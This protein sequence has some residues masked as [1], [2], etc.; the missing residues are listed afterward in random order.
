MNY[1]DLKELND[2]VA[3]DVKRRN[4]AV[5]GVA[6]NTNSP[7]PSKYHNQRTAYNGRI[8]DSK[9]EML[10]AQNNDLRVKAGEIAFWLYHV[11]FDLPGGAVYESDAVTFRFCPLPYFS[12][13][14]PDTWYIEVQEVK[15]YWLPAAKRKMKLFKATYPNIKITVK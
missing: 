5:F 12:S 8:Y 2:N 9:K 11:R 3:D 14:E 10:N 15:G 4:P 1:A 6:T 13:S 7:K